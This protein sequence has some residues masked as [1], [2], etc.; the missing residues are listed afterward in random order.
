MTKRPWTLAPYSGR[1]YLKCKAYGNLDFN[2]CY[3][4][5]PSQSYKFDHLLLIE[6]HNNKLRLVK[7]RNNFAIG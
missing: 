5:G 7:P 3:T 6:C 2:Y 4:E 1:C